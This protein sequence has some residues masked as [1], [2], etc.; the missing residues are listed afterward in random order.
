[1]GS[2]SISSMS[3]FLSILFIPKYS[4]KASQFRDILWEETGFSTLLSTS[5]YFL[6]LSS[7]LL[8][9]FSNFSPPFSLHSTSGSTIKSSFSCIFSLSIGRQTLFWFFSEICPSSICF[10]YYFANTSSLFSIQ[11]SSFSVFFFSSLSES[12]T[13]ISF[14][15]LEA[16][17]FPFEGLSSFFPFLF[18]EFPKPC[19]F[20]S[21][22]F[23]LLSVDFS[24]SSS[25]E[26]SSSSKED[27]DYSYIFFFSFLLASLTCFL[28]L[29]TLLRF[30]KP[31]LT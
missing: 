19:F 15:Y 8:W 2:I 12:I 3:S 23:L 24:D 6:S 21:I 29:M 17:L 25:L 26:M 4:S 16:Y 18:L 5:L 10:L 13:I 7:I 31:L 14:G 9:N 30:A 22:F 11:G 1:M 20:V 28:L 27:Y